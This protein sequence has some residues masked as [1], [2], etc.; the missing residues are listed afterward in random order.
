[1]QSLTA[2]RSAAF[3]H[4]SAIPLSAPKPLDGLSAHRVKSTS[5]LLGFSLRRTRFVYSGFVLSLKLNKGPNAL[6]V[7]SAARWSPVCP[8]TSSGAVML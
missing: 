2:T 4:I 5:H 8:V 6:Q 1:M 7:Q 3:L